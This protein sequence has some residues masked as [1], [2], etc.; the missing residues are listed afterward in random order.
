MKQ[1]NGENREKEHPEVKDKQIN[2]ITI[3][4]VKNPLK[5]RKRA[6]HT[7]EIIKAAIDQTHQK[8][9]EEY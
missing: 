8:H 6:K 1:S 3:E 9:Y 4:E 2:E 7:T 5:K